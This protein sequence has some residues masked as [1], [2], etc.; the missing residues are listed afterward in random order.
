VFE[1]VPFVRSGTLPFWKAIGVSRRCAFER[2]TLSTTALPHVHTH[3][4]SLHKAA[5]IGSF[6]DDVP[7]TF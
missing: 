7:E 6:V 5:A 2:K 1:T 3:H 4:A